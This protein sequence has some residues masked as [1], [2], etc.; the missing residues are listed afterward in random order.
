MQPWCDCILCAHCTQLH[1]PTAQVW[2]MALFKPS[3]RSI[4]PR[5]LRHACRVYA[6]V[7]YP[8]QVGAVQCSALQWA[9]RVEGR[10]GVRQACAL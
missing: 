9:G 3:T 1:V 5:P 7:F 8:L 4:R 6:A 10:A 2:E